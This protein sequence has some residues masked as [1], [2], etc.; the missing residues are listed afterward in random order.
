MRSYSRAIDRRAEDRGEEAEILFDAQVRVEREATGHVADAGAQRPQLLEHVT[1]EHRGMA[2]IGHEQRRQ[3]P[4]EGGLACAVRTD[5]AENL[6][7]PHR[8]RDVGESRRRAEALAEGIDDNGVSGSHRPV[9][10]S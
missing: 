6:L 3:N 5:Q 4:E 10:M 1:P 9:T 8:E 7:G 2:R